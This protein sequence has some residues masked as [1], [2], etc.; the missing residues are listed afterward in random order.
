[1][2]KNV[3]WCFLFFSF[4]K[5][6]N[7]FICSEFNKIQETISRTDCQNKQQRDLLVVNR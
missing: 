3:N 7:S 5:L 2:I 6:K 1:M 4:D